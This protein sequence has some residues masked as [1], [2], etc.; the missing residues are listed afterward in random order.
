[1]VFTS[2][3]SLVLWHISTIFVSLGTTFCKQPGLVQLL[4]I[5]L[6]AFG[7][8]LLSLLDSFINFSFLLIGLWS[9]SF[10]LFDLPVPADGYRIPFV[11]VGSGV[12]L[13]F[14][15]MNVGSLGSVPFHLL[16]FAHLISCSVL[17]FFL[18]PIFHLHCLN[19]P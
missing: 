9:P 12:L 14:T 10:V 16:A 17:E 5:F 3:S 15:V 7:M 11:N 19:S 18:C 4:W 2:F 13:P 6:R 1:M 8:S